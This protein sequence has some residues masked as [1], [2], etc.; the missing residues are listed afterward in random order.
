MYINPERNSSCSVSELQES[1]GVTIVNTYR[2]PE[3]SR[4]FCPRRGLLSLSLSELCQAPGLLVTPPIPPLYWHIAGLCQGCLS[5]LRHHFNCCLLFLILIQGVWE[6]LSATV[7]PLRLCHGHQ[8]VLH[9]PSTASFWG[10]GAI[11]VPFLLVWWVQRLWEK[12]VFS[13]TYVEKYP[14]RN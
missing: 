3:A 2:I 7:A 4:C 12:G 8:F 1:L 5:L 11:A 14:I 9:F 10:L 6:Q 13:L